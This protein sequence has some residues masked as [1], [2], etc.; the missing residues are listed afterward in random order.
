MGECGCGDG[1][2]M[3]QFPGPEGTVYTFDL[4]YG[5]AGC[6]NAVGITLHRY[7]GEAAEDCPVAGVDAMPWR[8]PGPARLDGTDWGYSCCTP[9]LIDPE[10]LADDIVEALGDL[11]CTFDGEQYKLSELL[12]TE[13]DLLYDVIARN[14]ER[15]FCAWLEAMKAARAREAEAEAGNGTATE[16][17]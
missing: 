8:T 6:A 16:S 7:Q 4:Y 2:G 1:F 9:P 11:D 10:T 3:W 14:M 13:S 12:Q 15:T 17:G 5:C